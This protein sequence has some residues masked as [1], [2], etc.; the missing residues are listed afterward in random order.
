MGC[1]HI[2]VAHP[3]PPSTQHGLE[4]NLSSVLNRCFSLRA[5]YEVSI[6]ETFASIIKF[7]QRH[8][9][10]P[11]SYKTLRQ[12]ALVLRDRHFIDMCACTRNE[13]CVYHHISLF[14]FAAR[15]L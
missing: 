4:T 12:V 5:F 6:R 3:S 8:Y 9:F 15:K 10:L 13:S 7:C 1:D 11:F 14:A 2:P